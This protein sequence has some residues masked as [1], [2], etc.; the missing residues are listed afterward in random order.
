MAQQSLS[1]FLVSVNSQSTIV[2][3]TNSFKVPW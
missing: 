2:T 1:L 3:V